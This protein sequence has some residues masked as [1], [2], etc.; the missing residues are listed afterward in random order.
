MTLSLLASFGI[1]VSRC[2]YETFSIAGSQAYVC[3]TGEYWIEG[4][5]SGV[6]FLLVAG[7][8]A[9]SVTVDG[10]NILSRQADR[11]ILDA[12][13]AAGGLAVIAGDSVTACKLP[14]QGFVFDATH[15]PD[16][17]PPLVVLACN[18]RGKTKIKGVERL[19]HK[20]SNRAMALVKE[21]S[22]L[23][24]RIHINGNWLEIEGTQLHGGVM[25]CQVLSRIF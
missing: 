10:M 11:K 21:F 20:E 16:L 9:G 24:A 18:C 25:Y 8:L 2:D 13:I 12:L 22:S 4:D 23:G 7:A 3:R 5:W 6:S 1:Q 17:F 15:C 14:L 19:V